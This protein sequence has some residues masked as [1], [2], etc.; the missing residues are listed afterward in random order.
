VIEATPEALE[1]WRA[2]I[3]AR[4]RHTVWVSGCR[5]WYLD[6]EGDALAWPDSWKRWVRGMRRPELRDFVS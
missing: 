4:M 3:R 2:T 5:S 6:A 1:R